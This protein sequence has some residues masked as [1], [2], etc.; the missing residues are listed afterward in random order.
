[1]NTPHRKNLRRLAQQQ[2]RQEAR[3]KASQE[4]FASMVPLSPSERAYRD[5]RATLSI[6]VHHEIDNP[7]WEAYRSLRKELS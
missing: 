6:P 5:F 1:M 3:V 4:F 2:R 7:S